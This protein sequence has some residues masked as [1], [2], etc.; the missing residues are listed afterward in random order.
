MASDRL[1]GNAVKVGNSSAAEVPVRKRTHEG[2]TISATGEKPGRR[3]N[4]NKSEDLP[5]MTDWFRSLR[6][7]GVNR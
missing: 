3:R 1:K 5:C 7:M 6:R 4:R 2:S